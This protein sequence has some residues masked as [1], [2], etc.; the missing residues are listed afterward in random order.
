MKDQEE[1]EEKLP[2]L[3]KKLKNIKN[4]FQNQAPLLKDKFQHLSSEDT[5]IEVIYQ[6]ELITKV[7]IQN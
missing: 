4:Q 5:T 1:M 3:Y 7:P 6:L 2:Q